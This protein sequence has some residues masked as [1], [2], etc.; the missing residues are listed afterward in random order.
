MYDDVGCSST[1]DI[2]DFQLHPEIVLVSGHC[3]FGDD[4]IGLGWRRCVVHS[5]IDGSQTRLPVLVVYYD[6]NPVPTICDLSR[7]PRELCS[8]AGGIGGEW[9]K[10]RVHAINVE[11][12]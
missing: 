3:V 7:I 2:L 6:S 1:A 11:I 9:F 8:R 4:E 12:R 5:D 10:F